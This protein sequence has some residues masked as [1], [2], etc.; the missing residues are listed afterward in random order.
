MVQARE[1]RASGLQLATP[2]FLAKPRQHLPDTMPQDPIPPHTTE[3]VML[4]VTPQGGICRTRPSG[5]PLFCV[6]VQPEPQLRTVLTVAH[7]LE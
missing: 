1:D 3:G 5:A 2:A 4:A 7:S 6:C